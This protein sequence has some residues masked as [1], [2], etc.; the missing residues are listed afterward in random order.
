LAA[1]IAVFLTAGSIECALYQLI[2]GHRRIEPGLYLANIALTTLQFLLLAALAL[3]LQVIANNKF[4]GYLLIVLFLISRILL[5]QLNFEHHLYDFGS[6]P[7]TPYSDMNGYGHFLAGHL[8]FSAYWACLAIAL[9]VLAAL[10]WVRGT[11]QGWRE[12]ARIARARF[13]AASP[14]ALGLS[15]A[16]F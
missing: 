1:V 5:K 6:A 12:R 2:R 14:L 10:Y 13:R 9:L 7:E 11:A 4:R 3:F 16:G 8:W 15:L